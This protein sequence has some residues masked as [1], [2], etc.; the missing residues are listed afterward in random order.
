MPRQPNPLVGT[1]SNMP[2][3]LSTSMLSHKT[4]TST[5]HLRNL[6]RNYQIA[7]KMPARL[8][9][10]TTQA[11]HKPAN[12][13]QMFPSKTCCGD[14]F[15]DIP[16]IR[17][18][19]TRKHVAL[20]S[21]EPY[22]GHLITSGTHRCIAHSSVDKST[23]SL[24]KSNPP[25]LKH[26]DSEPAYHYHTETTQ[27]TNFKPPLVRPFLGAQKAACATHLFADLLLHN[28]P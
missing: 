24:M 17:R 11:P 21:R 28:M 23:R 10:K 3:A 26:V 13:N 18:S 8:R 5:T 19:P 4:T 6:E 22:S 12:A 15:V 2:K 14:F 25:A 9:A 1:S 7:T 27:N 20:N 16:I